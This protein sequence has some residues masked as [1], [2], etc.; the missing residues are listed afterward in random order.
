MCI[1][2]TP[3]NSYIPRSSLTLYSIC[4]S[5]SSNLQL[6]IESRAEQRISL[7]NQSTYFW[8]WVFWRPSKYQGRDYQHMICS[9]QSITY[10]PFKTNRHWVLVT[11]DEPANRK[12]Y[13]QESPTLDK[14]VGWKLVQ[15][16]QEI[17]EAKWSLLWSS[18]LFLAAVEVK[19]N[20]KATQK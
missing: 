8:L 9:E 10:H 2:G 11:T 18:H 4:I 12:W 13:R 1:Q 19:H 15:V 6:H 5:I 20:F 17:I 16:R 14:N 3:F 7:F